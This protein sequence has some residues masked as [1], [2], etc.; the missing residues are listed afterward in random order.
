[1]ESELGGKRWWVDS[2]SAIKTLIID[3]A[4]RAFILD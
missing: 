2:G 3:I 4:T 1:M